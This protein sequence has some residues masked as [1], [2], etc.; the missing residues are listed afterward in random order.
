MDMVPPDPVAERRF[1]PPAAVPPLL[2]RL[3]RETRA[4]H[5][6]IE[7]LPALACLLSADLP[8]KA[9]IGALR[10]LHAFHARL[11]ASL[12]ALLRTLP[13]TADVPDVLDETGLVSLADDLAWFKARPK[14]M[15]R[16][17][18]GVATGEAALGALY[19]MEG[20]ALGA[21]VI[22]RAVQHSV[23]VAPGRGG[24]YFCGAAAETARQ[25]WQGFCRLLCDVE[26]LLDGAG[27]AEVVAGAL[28]SFACL[29]S[30]MAGPN[31]AAQDGPS[32]TLV[33]APPHMAAAIPSL[34]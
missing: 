30:A 7:T 2:A 32:R 11:H 27:I 3:R 26:P 4:A 1:T 14:R 20:S 29:E 5:D 8:V 15:M 18:Q 13:A 23:G 24:S 25:R 17:P 28:A 12:P 19:V 21:R 33:A 34:N 10:G 9:Y 22:G 16:M 6:R 31:A